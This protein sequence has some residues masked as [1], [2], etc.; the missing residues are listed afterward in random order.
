MDKKIRAPLYECL[1]AHEASRPV[2]F[3]V[4]G[5]RNGQAWR[6]DKEEQAIR[7][8]RFDRFGGI[9][10]I[11]V[12]E[13]SATDDLHAP[14]YAIAEAQRLAANLFGADESM[15]LVGGSTA[16]NIA[17]ILTVCEPGDLILVQRNVHKS[18]LNGLRLAGARAVFLQPAYETDEGTALV[19]PLDTVE[20]ALQRYPEARAVMLSTPNYYG[21][22]VMIRPYA[23]LAHSY[24][25][26]LLVDEAHG[27]HYGLHEAFPASAISQGADVVVQ[28]THKTLPAMTMGAML[29]VRERYID[30]ERLRDM[31]AVIQ[32]SSPSFPIMASL[33]IARAMIEEEGPAFFEA[34]LRQAALFRVEMKKRNGRLVAASDGKKQDQS[35]STTKTD[36]YGPKWNNDIRIDPLRVLL[37]DERGLVSGYE[38]L[39]MLEAHGCWAEMADEHR[40]LLLFG[41]Y[42]SDDETKRLLAACEAIEQVL[43]SDDK[44]HDKGRVGS[45]RLESA[46]D[47]VEVDQM[48]SEPILFTMDRVNRDTIT[49]VTLPDSVGY[50]SAETIIPYPP[51]IPLIYAGERIEQSVA[52]RLA[53]LAE[54][55]AKCQGASDPTLRT[56]RVIQ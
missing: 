10:S 55:G 29:H 45:Q 34:G 22:A 8:E 31:L 13:I 56:I 4:P 2:S 11:D 24:G 28:S 39:R 46:Q 17:M 23:D 33:D 52:T 14:E 53:R 18:V 54:M 21:R 37:H 43:E 5:H 41:P 32:S 9:L 48:I 50:I 19:P 12:T 42:V 40:V 35:V 6:T 47:E 27:A 51:G 7:H 26:P 25:I 16:G 49:T 3:H 30:L 44:E 36:V 1:T 15:L 20:Q 38:L